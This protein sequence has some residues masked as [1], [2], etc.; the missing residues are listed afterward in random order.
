MDSDTDD[1]VAPELIALLRCPETLQPLTLA[2]ATLLAQIE[3]RRIAGALMDRTGKR[4]A[5][6]IASGLVR[7]DQKIV[8]PIRD[9]IPILLVEEGIPLE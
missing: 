7:E 2:G 5:E 1:V 3:A 8:Y 9:G 4:V 6:V